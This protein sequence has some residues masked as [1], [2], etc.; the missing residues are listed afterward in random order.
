MLALLALTAAATT[1][2][3]DDDPGADFTSINDA[4]EAAAD[5]D[6]IAV[7]PGHYIEGRAHRIYFSALY[8][9]RDVDIVGA[10]PGVTV[11]EMAPHSSARSGAIGLDGSTLSATVRGMTLIN[12]D[13]GTSSGNYACAALSEST[14]YNQLNGTLNIEHVV[15]D[16]PVNHNKVIHYRNNAG[17]AVTFDHVTVDFGTERA[18]H[19]CYTNRSSANSVFRNG[20]VV[21]GTGTCS[22]YSGSALPFT[23]SVLDASVNP[24]GTGTFLGLA[25][26]V[27]RA[28]G[29]Y[30]LAAGSVAIDAGHPDERDADGTRTDLGAFGG[31]F[32]GASLCAVRFNQVDWHGVPVCIHPDAM[33]SELAELDYLATVDA[34]AFVAPRARLG[35]HSFVGPRS[36]LGRLAEVGAGARLG[37]DVVMAR[38]ASLGA[39]ATAADGT[40]FGYRAQAGSQATLSAQTLLGPHSSVGAHSRASD[41]LLARGASIG[42]QCTLGGETRLAPRASLADNVDV[43]G[44][45]VMRRGASVA[46][47][48]QLGDDVRM[49]RDAKLLAVQ[50]GNNVVVRDSACVGADLPAGSYVPMG[51]DTCPQ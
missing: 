2:T 33:V 8:L 41:L 37:S 30:R 34:D 29:D 5:G 9:S 16:M 17:L 22:V 23:Y 46:S 15:F 39:G 20:I 51:T 45:L 50:V 28:Q 3:V 42:E 18:G 31:V 19:N 10:G 47:G 4:I 13:C 27:D 43:A 38:E 32:E 25:T 40:V 1:W 44:S 48:A 26:F 12:S 7:A 24:G 36:V 14:N 11:V 6:T 21:N 49:G 35:A